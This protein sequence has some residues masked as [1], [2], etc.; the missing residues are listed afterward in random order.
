[1]FEGKLFRR[2]IYVDFR[3]VPDCEMDILIA[4]V[5]FLEQL[6][7]QERLL[8]DPNGQPCVDRILAADAIGVPSANFLFTN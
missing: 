3:F 4:E 7:E 6:D 1:M 2:D 8:I 5:C